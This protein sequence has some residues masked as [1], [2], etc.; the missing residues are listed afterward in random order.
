MAMIKPYSHLPILPLIGAGGVQLGNTAAEVLAR[1]GKP[2]RTAPVTAVTEGRE[3]W[4][5]GPLSIWLQHG[6]VYN[7]VAELG[8]VGITAE[9]LRVGVPWREAWRIYP[10]LAYYEE[11]AMWCVPGLN[12]ISFDFVRP[13]HEGEFNIL[14]L[15]WDP[16]YLEPWVDEIY[17]I[18]DREQAFLCS[19]TL[20]DIYFSDL[21]SPPA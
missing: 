12:G 10:T 17:E 13:L 15:S 3:G 2:L 4:Q 19:V 8:Y 1:L 20:H 6:V 5:Y 14:D 18:T 11:E 9:G 7:I 16:P 21:S